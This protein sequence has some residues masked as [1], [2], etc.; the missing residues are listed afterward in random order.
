MD[1]YKM[2]LQM[3]SEDIQQRNDKGI[4][5]LTTANIISPYI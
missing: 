1:D 3:Y 5:N 2:L 4:R